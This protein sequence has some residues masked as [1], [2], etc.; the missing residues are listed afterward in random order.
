MSMKSWFSNHSPFLRSDL[1]GVSNAEL[2]L[3]GLRHG[4]T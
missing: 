2:P 3:H 4:S 1:K